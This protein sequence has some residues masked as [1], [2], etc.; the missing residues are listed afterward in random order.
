MSR[1]SL[2]ALVVAALIVVLPARAQGQ[3]PTGGLQYAA[4]PTAATVGPDGSAVAPAGA[5]AQVLALIDAGNRIARLPY[6]YGGGHATLLD[7]GYDCSGSVSFALNGAGLLGAPLDSTALSRWGLAGAGTWINV[8]ANRSHAFLVV[9]GLRFDTSGATKA[10]SRWQ[11][12]P[13][14]ARGFR[15]RHPLGL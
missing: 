5:P 14:T 9:A 12:A 8:Y 13:R 2:F 1:R 3:A 15:V 10:G 6:R 11:A 7:T 4:A